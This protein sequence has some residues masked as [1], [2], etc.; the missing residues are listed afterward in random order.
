M[1]FALDGGEDAEIRDRAVVAA[2]LSFT[3]SDPRLPDNP[4]VFVNPAFERTTG[5]SRE[6]VQGR[7]CRF[8]QGPDTD[9]A[10]VQAVRDALRG[11]EHRD[12]HA[13]QLPQGRHGLLERAGRS[14]RSSTPPAS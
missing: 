7:N 2:G 14:R 5:Y 10:A 9:P 4:L 13:A 11:Q 3:I 12:D 6:E 8:L 1:L